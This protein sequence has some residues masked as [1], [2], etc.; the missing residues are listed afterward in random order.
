MRKLLASALALV[1]I[2][3]L[4]GYGFWTQQRP[5]GHYLSDLRIE[6]ALNQG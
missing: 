2:A 4:C 5:E 3:A 1:M 6:L